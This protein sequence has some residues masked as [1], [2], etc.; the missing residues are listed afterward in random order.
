MKSEIKNIAGFLAVCI[1]A[2]GVYSEEEKEILGEISEALEVDQKDLS[3]QIDSALETLKEM[4]DDAVQD[5]LVAHASAIE[6]G[7]EKTLLQCAI[8]TILADQVISAEEI[9][10]LFELADATGGDIDHADVTLM[11]LDLVKY[12]PEMEIEF[13]E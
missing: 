13:R 6:E 5:F 4:D 10:V 3:D 9:D 7:E 12:S 2:D 8:E 11:L 1:W